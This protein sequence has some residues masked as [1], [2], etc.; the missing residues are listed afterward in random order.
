MQHTLWGNFRAILFNAC[1]CPVR[2]K[3][4]QKMRYV[5]CVLNSGMGRN[6]LQF[7]W[8]CSSCALCHMCSTLL[9]LTR[10]K[11]GRCSPELFRV[12]PFEVQL[13]AQAWV[14]T[15][16]SEFKKKK[17]MCAPIHP[18]S[19]SLWSPDSADNMWFSAERLSENAKTISLSSWKLTILQCVTNKGQELLKSLAKSPKSL[20]IM[21]LVSDLFT[22]CFQMVHF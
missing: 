12:T 8:S 10:T 5:A 16:A 17:S 4:L 9:S 22:F 11:T 14:P 15:S 19:E 7:T 21:F 6:M 3:E 18:K 1:Y 2:F 13:K 20:I